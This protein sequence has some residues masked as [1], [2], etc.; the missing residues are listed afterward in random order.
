MAKSPRAKQAV[1]VKAAASPAIAVKAAV[2]AAL[3]EQGPAEQGT[4]EAAGGEHGGE[5]PWPETAASIASQ[6]AYA[7]PV[8]NPRTAAE[9]G[10]QFG[11]SPG[12]FI[13]VPNP[14]LR[15]Q[16]ISVRASVPSRRRAGFAFTQKATE[17]SVDDLSEGQLDMIIADPQ[18]IITVV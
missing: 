16:V 13:A 11:H 14:D 7:P 10:M 1:A 8:A 18:L 12:A 4:M 2:I 5:R 9:A 3:A 6:G 17:L 15:G